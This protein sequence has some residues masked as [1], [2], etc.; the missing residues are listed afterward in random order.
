MDMAKV[1]V[2]NIKGLT[3]MQVDSE[4]YLG[5]YFLTNYGKWQV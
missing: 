4:N 1:Q 3:R 5:I 2:I